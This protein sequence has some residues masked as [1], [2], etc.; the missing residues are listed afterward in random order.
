MTLSLL[1]SLAG[2]ILMSWATWCILS[3][4]F[5]DGI[6]GKIMF[7][8]LAIAAYAVMTGPTR[9]YIN[10]PI[11]ELTINVCMAGLAI[12]HWFLKQIWPHIAAVYRQHFKG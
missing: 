4:H 1:N 12:R 2:L 10:P 6:V 11:A 9:G 3:P 8:A 5:D 7:S